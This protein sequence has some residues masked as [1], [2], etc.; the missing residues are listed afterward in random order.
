MGRTRSSELPPELKQ[1]LRRARRLEW[2]TIAY[3]VSAVV[4]LALVLGSSQAM[5]TAWIED[6]LSL[7]PPIAFLLAMRFNSHSPTRRF[8]YGFHRTVSIAHLCSALALFVMGTYLLVESVIKLV[9]AEYPTIN[10]VE[11]FGQTV[12]LGWLMLP[13]LAW[14]G[15]PAVFLGRAKIPLAEDLHNK[16]LYADAKMNKADWLTA[17]AAMV[18]VVGIG[19][20]LWWLDA[21]AAA[22]ISLDITKD[23]VSNLRRAV[24]DLMD[25]APTTVDHDETD[26]L[27]G[28]LAAMLQD[29]EWVE[30]VDLRLRE[31]GQVYFGEALVVPSDETNITEKIE[32]ALKQ[33]RDLD[34]RIHDLALTPVL[35]LPEKDQ[36]T[37]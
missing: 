29:L 19:F 4:L 10:S 35:E 18:G 23:G 2:L 9:T 20:G 31:E 3:L 13:A 12:W 15:L 8:P 32:A 14:S 36:S 7:I 5:K 17:G 27:R 33:A 28:K 37:R 11:I 25:Q 30:E 6:L 24:V 16:V 1:T 21:V 26:P 34:W 22:L